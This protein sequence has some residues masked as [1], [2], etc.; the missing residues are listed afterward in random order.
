MLF[1]LGIKYGS[2]D[3]K[4]ITKEIFS[5][6]FNTALIASSEIAKEKGVFPKYEDSVLKSE[7]VNKYATQETKS[8]IKEHG[9]RNCSLISIAPTGSIANMLGVSG[10][11]EPEFA[12]SYNRKTENLNETYRIYLNSV[13]EYMEI[14]N[15]KDDNLPE[16]FVASADIYWK[17][18]VD[19]QAIMQNYVDTAIS[20]TVN[21]HKDIPINDVEEIYLYAWCL[22]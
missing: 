12:L 11:C 3:A 21:L 13:K 6:M 16:Y 20:S 5:F 22:S 18:R 1:E 19:V 15:V 7:I 4:K 17:D 14:N 8:I 9:L 2:D 10:G